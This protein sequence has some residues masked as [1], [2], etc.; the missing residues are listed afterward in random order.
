[1]TSLPP[2]V[3]IKPPMTSLPRRVAINYA[4]V[5]ACFCVWGWAVVWGQ[6]VLLWGLWVLL[7]LFVL[8][9]C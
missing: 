1:M 2:R 6:G 9:C 4:Y 8:F 7:L 3:A 5:Y